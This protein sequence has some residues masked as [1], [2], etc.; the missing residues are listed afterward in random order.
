MRVRLSLK[1]DSW[2]GQAVLGAALGSKC[3]CP[4][5]LCPAGSLLRCRQ[6]GS[7]RSAMQ[8]TH[9]LLFML[10]GQ[11]LLLQPLPQLRHLL[12]CLQHVAQHG[13]H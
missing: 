1:W 9:P 8:Q 11:L 5:V 12:L 13:T 6:A 10:V 3:V 7:I 2:R 4:A